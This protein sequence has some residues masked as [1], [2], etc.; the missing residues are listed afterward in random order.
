M[1]F[2]R[3]KELRFQFGG[4][5]TNDP[6]DALANTKYR[7]AVN[8]RGMAGQ[9]IRTRPGY[10]QLFTANGLV[11]DIR[12]YATLSTDDLPR[13]L[14]RRSN[15]AIY[16]DN[17]LVVGSLTGSAQ[18]V[19]MIPYRP[20]QSP[21]S[22][23]Y[24]ASPND[25]QK[26][27]A[28][29]TLNVV[30]QYKVGIREPQSPPE[31]SPLSL[32]F[33]DFT[34]LAAT[35]AQG[36][37]AGVPANA[38]RLSDIATAVFTDPA[39]N[40][41]R[42]YVQVATNKSYQ[43][44]MLVNMVKSTGGSFNTIVEDVFPPIQTGATI[45]IKSIY[46]FTGVTGRCIIVPSQIPNA[47]L[48]RGSLIALSAGA[49]T[50]LV[51]S[52]TTGP[53][54][55]IA[56]ETSTIGTHAA[57]EII[58]GLPSI[59]VSAINA[60]VVAQVISSAD[61][62][63]VLTGPGIGTLTKPLATNPFASV[64]AP[65]TSL[66]QSDDYIV[67]GIQVDNISRLVQGTITFDIK[68]GGADYVTDTLYTTFDISNLMFSAIAAKRTDLMLTPEQ[69]E[70]IQTSINYLGPAPSTSL[71]PSSMPTGVDLYNAINSA[72]PEQVA[73]YQAYMAWLQQASAITQTITSL[74]PLPALPRATLMIPIRS[75]IRVG[76][77]NSRSL[78]NCQGVRISV[79]STD[80]VNI[81][82]SSFCLIGGGQPDV[83]NNVTYQ[84]CFR[85]RNKL[86]GAK[87]NR[88]PITRYGVSPRRQS[89]RVEMTDTI[90]DPQADVFDV[91]RYGG[92][93]TSWQWIGSVANSGTPVVFTDNVFDTAAVGGDI[94][95]TNNYEPWP[96]V[97]L[98]YSATT[99]IAAGVTTSIQCLGTCIIVTYSSAAAFTNP[100]PATI[101]R[102][103]PGTLIDING[104]GSFT[105]R[106]R[107]VAITLA[108]PPAAFYYAYRFEIIENSGYNIPASLQILE[109]NLA[110][111]ILPYL[112]GP[113]TQGDIFGCGDPLRPGTVYFIKEHDPDSAPDSYNLELTTPSEPLLGGDIVGGSSL[114]AS[115]KRWWAL[116]PAFDTPQRYYA[117][118]R[119]IGRG[120]AA[121]YGHYAD[122]KL[123]WFVAKD[124]IW[125]TDG[126][127]GESVTDM[128]L[129]N[130][131]P[132][133][134]VAGQN[135]IYQ[136]NTI[137]APDYKRASTFRLGGANGFVYFDYQDTTGAYHTL[138]YDTK[139]KAWCL[140]EYDVP[141]S[142]HYG[143]EQQE[144]TLLTPNTL[145]P[146]LIQG[147]NTGVVGKQQ[148]LVNDNG[149]NI[150]AKLGTAEY[151][152]GDAR[153]N[154][155]WNDVLLDAIPS[156]GI[157]VTPVSDATAIA[158]VTNIPAALIRTRTPVNVNATAKYL[159]L[160]IS[161]T[162]TL[163]A[164][165]TNLFLAQPLYEILP[166]A[167]YNWQ[168]E[169]MG[170]GIKGYKSI[171]KML[172]AYRATAAVT[173][174]ITAYDGY[175][176]TV[177]TLPSTGGAYRKTL[178]TFTANKALLYFFSASCAALWQPYFDEWEIHVAPW[179]RQDMCM[180]FKDI[181]KP[182]GDGQ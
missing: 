150:T 60:T 91:Y 28:P 24:I 109:P 69:Q 152:G 6:L 29:D 37:T 71:L 100:A 78:A 111:Q 93:I 110:R 13:I 158:A 141:C 5:N 127:T 169:G 16:L 103:L 86:T 75:L 12:A 76:N 66:A 64:L 35:W 31:A 97:D 182:I 57:A 25:Y 140:D 113:N 51:L 85:G 177:I 90:I 39:S 131:F 165:P 126:S 42:W 119:Q 118:E 122:G 27:S 170:F 7:L 33:Y 154:I 11:T 92:T 143:V 102:W 70:S 80:T 96:S 10:T 41:I 22:W 174:T 44:G 63:S 47:N 160:Y 94:L 173:L 36:G 19:C 15:N 53:D 168:P 146:M 20:N 89:V 161:W 171:W 136:G 34:G 106:N 38:V 149:T 155:L 164:S 2:T 128:D 116:N 82:I 153:G 52:V 125:V 55:T 132:H 17:G 120:L 166:I 59:A 172:V 144:G 3:S 175:A 108:A 121:P 105:L 61:I 72:T 9:S 18:G 130:L 176:P 50:C 73:Q 88:S 45:T 84:Y 98:P 46:Y 4:M 49:E 159:G 87:G 115:S 104:L 137:Y 124:G 26:F 77:D 179:G 139:L 162:D 167:L 147:F 145:Y 74:T 133:E 30:T 112:W 67:L 151:N 32:N 135:L 129:Y 65:S 1:P 181:T 79:Q 8:I 156:S 138:V 14:A 48:R 40:S 163:P 58:T 117:V 95:E 56:I 107:P 54:G 123:L 68:N 178:F 99:G 114:I 142:V 134:G 180:V 148:D 157:S 83:G 62:T 43:V 101:I 23:M 81:A 21:Q